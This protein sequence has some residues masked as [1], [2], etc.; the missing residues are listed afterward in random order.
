[1]SLGLSQSRSANESWRVNAAIEHSAA[2]R[3][4]C[5][6]R[7]TRALQQRLADLD[8]GERRGQGRRR[9]RARQ[10]EGTV[11]SGSFSAGT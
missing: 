1:M 6:Q 10:A 4:C 9:R 5:V 7:P 11:P 2:L 3:L 8:A